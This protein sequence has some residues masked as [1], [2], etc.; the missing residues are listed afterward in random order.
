M[1]KQST[2]GFWQVLA[3]G[4][5]ALATVG[6][7]VAAQGGPGSNEKVPCSTDG[8]V[9]CQNGGR[10]TAA[11]CCPT[12]CAVAQWEC[13]ERLHESCSQQR[14]HPTCPTVICK[15]GY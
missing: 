8:Q 12:S 5:I 9:G 6:M 15:G 14:P 11:C 10:L 4:M 3:G 2:A 1:S 13:I 7:T